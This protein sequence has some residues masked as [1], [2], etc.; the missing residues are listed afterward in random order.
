[1][2]KYTP[3]PLSSKLKTYESNVYGRESTFISAATAISDSV[4]EGLL[5]YQ[6]A[7]SN[8]GAACHDA[9]GQYLVQDLT[10]VSEACSRLKQS[11]ITD[12]SDICSKCSEVD[13]TID[14]IKELQN[15]VASLDKSLWIEEAWDDLGNFITG[16]WNN[17]NH[18]QAKQ[19]NE[20]I[21]QLIKCAETQLNSIANSSSSI[22]LG[23]DQSNMVHGGA[24]G[25][26]TS[27]SDTYSFNKQQWIEDN[28][29]VH[30]NVLQQAGC[31]V[32]G[33]VEGVVKVVE[34]VGDAVLT[35]CAGVTSLITGDDDNWF[36]R[37]A[38]YDLAGKVGEG[39]SYV[40]TLGTV[41]ADQYHESAGRSVGNFV[42]S[43]VAHGVLWA[44]GLGI[45]SAVSIAGN[46]M[47]KHLKDGDT[48]GGS[49][50]S[51]LWDGTKAYVMGHAFSAIGGKIEIGRAHV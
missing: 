20:K 11:M 2:S 36:R 18:G 22:D 1:M 47:E 35:V 28:P 37:A 43:A 49:L 14:E 3:E 40:L 19:K 27:F 25:A 16:H 15:Q 23:I 48:V 51:G 13:G 8:I 42:G 26:Y 5:K 4:N 50:L 17:S 7:A 44:S 30:L 12:M 24:L 41:N 32:A 6:E 10:L 29:I 31:L 38:E 46:S 33:A 21:K 45:V 34:G 39:A 9:Q